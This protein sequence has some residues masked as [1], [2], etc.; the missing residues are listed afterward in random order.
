MK[1]NLVIPA[2][3]LGSR[4]RAIGNA[5]PKPLIDISGLPMI[6]WVVGNF[7]LYPED[8]IW[9]ISQKQDDL[10]VRLDE[11]FSKLGN[12]VHFIEIE[13]L[14]DGAATTL[15]IVLGQLPLH[16]PVIC[17]N[18]D[19]YVSANLKEFVDSVR[20]GLADGQILTMEAE[21]NKH[22]PVG[23]FVRHRH[24]PKLRG[25]RPDNEHL[26]FLRQPCFGRCKGVSAKNNSLRQPLW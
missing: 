10:P 18:S 26:L 16:E 11:P 23:G 19:Q 5:T 24:W 2:A 25:N 4:F 22:Y 9:V 7:E 1:L 21:G 3:G 20:S 8:E 15:Q 13:G 6:A 17:A 12:K 14:T